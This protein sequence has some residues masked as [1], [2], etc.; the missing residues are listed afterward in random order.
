MHHRRVLP[1]MLVIAG[2]LAGCNPDVST[3]PVGPDTNSSFA[4]RVEIIQSAVDRW[5]DAPDL[6][7]ARA[8]AEEAANLVVG[9]DGPDFGDRDGNG[10]VDGNAD[11]GLLTGATDATSGLATDLR[12]VGCVD[13]DVLGATAD[14]VDAG[15]MA[16][17]TAIANWTPSNN[18]MPSLASHPQRIVGWATFTQSASDLDLA[19]EYAGH[20]QL[21]VD[22]TRAAPTC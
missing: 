4:T 15:W 1:L 9:P 8:A 20:A 11:V 12:G 19:V 13:R 17:L 22:V 18:T 21:H 16:M 7:T 5:R 6:D 14:D 2:S 10:T 3:T